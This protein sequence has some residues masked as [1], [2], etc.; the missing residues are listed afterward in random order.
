MATKKTSSLTKLEDAYKEKLD[1]EQKLAEDIG[2]I[3]R[4]LQ[5]LYAKQGRQEQWMPQG[6]PLIASCFSG[7]LQPHYKAGGG[8]CCG[9]VTYGGKAKNGKDSPLEEP[10]A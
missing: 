5:Q 1:K 3:E 6:G 10:P 4:R 9:G 8:P 2:D 7:S